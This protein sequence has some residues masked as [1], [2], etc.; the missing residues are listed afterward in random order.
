MR[1]F[2]ITLYFLCA[3][4]GPD[5]DSRDICSSLTGN[6]FVVTHIEAVRSWEEVSQEVLLVD[7][8]HLIPRHLLHQHQACGD[9]VGRHVLPAINTGVNTLKTV[10]CREEDK[11]RHA[12]TTTLINVHTWMGICTHTHEQQG[13]K[14]KN[15]KQL[16][17]KG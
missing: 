2:S 13:K 4:W 16:Q 12:C 9:G 15:R 3:I 14:T 10:Y 7:L 17:N 5:G 1:C 6:L 8:A 11:H